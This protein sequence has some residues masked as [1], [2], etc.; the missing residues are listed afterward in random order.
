MTYFHP[1]EAARFPYLR[2]ALAA[3]GRAIAANFE[4][5]ARRRRIGKLDALDDR[6]LRD[7]GLT[8]DDINYA[9][10]NPDTPD[11]TLRRRS[12]TNRRTD[13]E[14]PRLRAH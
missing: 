8:R 12:L 7:I 10:S 5:R 4:T 1:A 6:L 13:L 3:L 14:R 2:R 9:L 11:E